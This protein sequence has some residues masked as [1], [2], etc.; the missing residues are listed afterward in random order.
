MD[1][2]VTYTRPRYRRQVDAE[3]TA[4]SLVDR[5]HTVTEVLHW[6]APLTGEAAHRERV[7]YQQWEAFDGVETAVSAG[8]EEYVHIQNAEHEAFESL[9][10]SLP[11]RYYAG[12]QAPGG[13]Q[14][15]QGP[16]Q[17]HH[18]RQRSDGRRQQGE[19]EESKDEAA[20]AGGGDGWREAQRPL[21]PSMQEGPG[22][23]GTQGGGDA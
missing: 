5:E 12:H 21:S 10:S 17:G 23:W 13:Q 19:E 22:A 6:E 7:A 1:L 9:R 4:Q 15:Q 11:D 16:Q 14:E 18:R 2:P 20:A 3:G 8:E